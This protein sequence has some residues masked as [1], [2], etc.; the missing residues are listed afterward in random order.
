MVA[1]APSLT[2]E[3]SLVLLTKTRN[4]F[5]GIWNDPKGTVNTENLAKYYEVPIESIFEILKVHHEE[6]S[7]DRSGDDWTPRAAIRLGMLLDSPMSRSI[8]TLALDL[9]EA[10]KDKTKRQQIT[11]L[12][13]NGDFVEWSNREIAR[14]LNCSHTEVNR[15]RRRLE[16]TNKVVK[17]EKRKHIRDGKEIQLTTNPRISPEP[18]WIYSL[19]DK[20]IVY[21]VQADGT[22]L[23]K[24]G[25]T[26]DFVQRVTA[27]KAGCPQKMLLKYYIECENSFSA[28]N[29]E[30]RIHKIFSNQRLRDDSEWFKLTHQEIQEIICSVIE[31]SQYLWNSEFHEQDL[32]VD[33]LVENCKE[34]LQTSNT[35]SCVAPKVKVSMPGD[36]RDGMEVVV[37]E[38]K[39]NSRQVLA[40][41]PDGTEVISIDSLD[42]PSSPY[43]PINRVSHQ[44]TY[45]E[46]ELQAKI[47]RA[48]ACALQEKEIGDRSSIREEI[49]K[50]VREEVKA[51]QAI[52]NQKTLEVVKLQRQLVELEGLRRLEEENQQ[53]RQEIEHLK[54]SMRDQPELRWQNTYSQQATKVLNAE[55]KKAVENLEPE[56][57]LRAMAKTAPQSNPRGTVNLLGLSLIAMANGHPRLAKELRKA[58]AIVLDV[59]E[60]LIDAKKQQL[61][62]LPQ[63][64]ASF[65]NILSSPEVTWRQVV[66]TGDR[67]ELVKNDIWLGLTQSEKDLIDKLSADF[68]QIGRVAWSKSLGKKIRIEAIHPNKFADVCVEGEGRLQKL[69]FLDIKPLSQ[70]EDEFFPELPQVQVGSRVAR[71]DINNRDYDKVGTVTDIRD[72]VAWVHW[73]EFEHPLLTH[74]YGI[75]ELRICE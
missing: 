33:S 22:D 56:L 60:D 14:V 18:H 34:V 69:S 58:A 10:Q 23:F 21:F 48:I 32:N 24:I 43:T 37:R 27:L 62:Q 74:N 17:L 19:I 68:Y 49:E 20:H 39:N 70:N 46:E 44:R 40:D 71:N 41:F 73:D 13:Q 64:I 38:I 29:T 26:S 7:E 9:I 63:A 66:E 67:Y 6:F 55:V 12:L 25:H 54:E 4:L 65:K 28:R 50:E 57:H 3:Q 35:D 51:A 8:R 16:A 42:A 1:S 36:P 72:G 53:L 59:K 75:E 2:Q 5:S 11:L 47:E 15:I 52:A 30:Q 61:E 31:P 45:T